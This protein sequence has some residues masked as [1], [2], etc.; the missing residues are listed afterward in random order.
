[1]IREVSTQHVEAGMR[2]VQDAHHTENQR[3]SRRQHKQQQSV[4]KTIQ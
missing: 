3:Q 4:G 2:E 1:L